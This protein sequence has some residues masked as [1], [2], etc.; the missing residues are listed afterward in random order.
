MKN[1]HSTSEEFLKRKLRH[2]CHYRG[3]CELDLILRRFIAMKRDANITDWHL[4]EQFLS[5]P[6]HNLA[7]WLISNE[8]APNEY[9]ALVKLIKNTG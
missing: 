3:T 6:E 5:E 8:F 7:A 2:Q 1:A 4:F 9:Q